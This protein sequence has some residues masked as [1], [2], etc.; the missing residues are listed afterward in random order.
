MNDET[1]GILAPQLEEAVREQ[2]QAFGQSE[3]VANR[4]I[5]WLYSVAQGEE[6]LSRKEDVQR[7]LESIYDALTIEGGQ[8]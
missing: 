3:T 6:V 8:E 7:R 1:R 5:A 4:I 2:V